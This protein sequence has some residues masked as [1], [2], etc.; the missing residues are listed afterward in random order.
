MSMFDKVFNRRQAEEIIRS[1]DR[2][3]P[4][5]SLTEKFPVLHYGPTPRPNLASWDFRV[6]GEVEEEITW[7]WEAFNQL[8]RTQVT[9]DLHCVTRWSKFD[10]VWEGVSLGQL[11][12]EGIIKPKSGAKY[13]IQHC[14]YCWTQS[15][16]S[17][18]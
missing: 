5:Q 12:R 14:E 18:N 7:D 13:V 11:V 4:G 2:L 10:T 15:I 9:M 3:P 6:F 1:Q 8:P 16:M 17:L